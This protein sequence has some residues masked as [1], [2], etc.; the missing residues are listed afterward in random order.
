MEKTIIYCER[1]GK[2][3]RAEFDGY[4]E[5]KASYIGRKGFT[6]GRPLSFK[7]NRVVYICPVCREE[8]RTFGKRVEKILKGY[9]YIYI[10]SEGKIIHHKEKYISPEERERKRLINRIADALIELQWE[11]D[12]ECRQYKLICIT[13]DLNSLGMTLKE[14]QEKYKDKLNPNPEVWE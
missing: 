10:L 1:C 7:R 14:F 5:E 12:E 13:K 9:K 2:F 8:G 3:R 6:H 4:V 11:D